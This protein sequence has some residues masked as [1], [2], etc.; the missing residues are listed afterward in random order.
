MK[1][2]LAAVCIALLASA[3]AFAQ[4]DGQGQKRDGA[5]RIEKA[6]AEKVAFITAELDLTEAQAQQFWPVYNAVQK[7]R[8][9]A[10]AAMRQAYKALRKGLKEEA[11]AEPLLKAY[12]DA[13]AKCD[14]LESEAV[15]R[16]KK[17]LP[18]EKVA[19]LVLAEENFR[20]KQIGHGGGGPGKGGRGPGKKD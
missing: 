2:L 4:K 14:A 7:E 9:E 20:H 3:S 13:K 1:R 10:F 17:V 6:R 8:R 18:I 16:Y 12:L 19:R 5:Q 15:P 11:D